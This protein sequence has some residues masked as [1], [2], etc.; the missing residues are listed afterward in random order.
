MKTKLSKTLKLAALIGAVLGILFRT[1]VMDE[2][3]NLF[4]FVV[5]GILPGGLLGAL[6]GYVIDRVRKGRGRL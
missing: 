2:D 5:F 3:G 1:L 6:V 4:V